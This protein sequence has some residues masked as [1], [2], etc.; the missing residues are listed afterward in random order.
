MRFSRLPQTRPEA[1]KEKNN[2]D[3]TCRRAAGCASEGIARPRF[4]GSDEFRVQF[5]QAPANVKKEAPSFD[6]P[7]AIGMLAANDQLIS[8]KLDHCSRIV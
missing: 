8:D 7:I 5:S 3:C 4:D 6:L 2:L 1:P